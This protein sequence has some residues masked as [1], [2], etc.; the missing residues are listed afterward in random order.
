[1]RI[2][3]LS[4]LHFGL[5]AN[6]KRTQT[7]KNL[8]D[9]Y[10]NG[11]FKKLE[12]IPSVDYILISGDIAFSGTKEEY[13]EAEGWIIKLADI[14]K[15]TTDRIFLCPGNHDVDREELEDKEVP[16]LQT[17]ANELLCI[18]MFDKLS[19]RFNEYIA[20]CA[21]LGVAS[22][23]L[24]G[25]SNYL[26]GIHSAPE[27]NVICVNTSWFAKND[28]YEKSMWV[29]SNF[30]E[31]MIQ[32]DFRNDS[33]TVAIMHHPTSC[34]NE[35]EYRNYEKNENVF[36]KICQMSDI[37]LY[38]HTHEIE[39]DHYY[40]NETY[41]CG[42]GA[43]YKDTQYFHNFHIYE[44]NS[45]NE[46]NKHKMEKIAYIYNGRKWT[47]S[48]IFVDVF[49]KRKAR[50]EKQSIVSVEQNE[51]REEQLDLILQEL[52][53][54]VS[55]QYID[56]LVMEIRND[57]ERIKRLE[58]LLTAIIEN[59]ENP[60]DKI[61]WDN[62]VDSLK[63]VNSKRKIGLSLEGYEG[64]GKS[65][66]LSL[67]YL[68]LRQLNK[69]KKTDR[70]PVLID[71]HLFDTMTLEEA[72]TKLDENLSYIDRVILE[73]N[74]S[75]YLIF[76]GCDNYPR[77]NNELEGK[78]VE[79][80]KK[81][82]GKFILCLGNANEIDRGRTE[83]FHSP[84]HSVAAESSI[85]LKMNLI[86]VKNENLKT[87]LIELRFVLSS[88]KNIEKVSGITSLLRA[89]ALEC[90][91]FRTL[92]MFTKISER[93]GTNL[94][95]SMAIILYEYLLDMTGSVDT[96]F[97]IARISTI[98]TISNED[99]DDVSLNQY[100]HIIYRNK[101]IRDFLFAYYF[102]ETINK[103]KA[104]KENDIERLG[105]IAFIFTAGINRLAKELFVELSNA[106]QL[107]SVNKLIELY[108]S[109]K[110]T[111][112]MKSQ[113][114]YF[115]GRFT[116]QNVKRVIN[117]F[118]ITEIEKIEEE[119]YYKKRISDENNLE[120]KLVLYRTISVSLIAIG[121]AKYE[122]GYIQHLL[123]DEKLKSLN[124]GFH[125]EYYSDRAYRLGDNPNFYDDLE[126]PV[127]KTFPY[128]IG[129][130]N[131]KLD[132]EK[133]SY[134]L[135]LDIITLYSIFESRLQNRQIYHKY[136]DELVILAN[137]ILYSTIVMSPTVKSYISTILELIQANEP[138]YRYI[139]NELYRIKKEKRAGWV[140]RKISDP[141]S[142][143]DH[144]Y[145]SYILGTFLLPDTIDE[146]K[147]YTGITDFDK[148]KNEYNKDTI[149][150]TLLI[151]DLGE[152]Y[153]GDKIDKSETDIAREN[154][155]FTYY[156]LLCTLKNIYGMKQN[157][158]LWDD[159]FQLK[160]INAQ[161]A[162]DVD[163]LEAL[164]QAYMY[165]QDKN[166]VKLKEWIESVVSSLKTS[167]GEALLKL[168]LDNI[169][170]SDE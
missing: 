9:N 35:G 97:E 73:K 129:C 151:H 22:F 157:K 53:K 5:K 84:L 23:S 108:K 82:K 64:T 7:E 80:I 38:G 117:S 169:I 86:P 77:K 125:V 58:N 159:F 10:F 75:I 71:L 57:K 61:D 139:F 62:I 116:S 29:G 112:P 79:Y 163:K 49:N 25:R 134:T 46:S 90:V 149:L 54:N 165:Y 14:C 144:I 164:V 81:H 12:N 167:L 126:T 32:E 107:N 102:V 143:A 4:D 85:R 104:S 105:K 68:R 30:I 152:A 98:Y 95:K 131:S 70:Y 146:L 19:L 158:P 127:D 138:T 74:I 33:I 89:G 17:R 170:A 28:T 60:K 52:E 156:A 103:N 21:R 83:S 93:A 122:E 55:Y 141:E 76:D 109:E 8:R 72:Q 43:V 16:V 137:K 153:I 36:A 34:W 87:L 63:Q 66:F 51:N 65:T 47:E 56:S 136:K 154:E 132:N 26:V 3:H 121:E 67:L 24:N 96:L 113:I 101:L 150:K 42:G 162:Y 59:V 142:I 166:N 94:K 124:C 128:L 20:F 1:M 145:G 15:V 45:G 11:F 100:M 88:N 40:Q 50:G 37:I 6:R 99:I 18:E 140:K 161:I 44:I 114:C 111:M 155:R 135:Y 39:N 106:G 78:I 92:I 120:M 41:I 168:I 118:L 2:L 31:M 130:I 147:D 48:S 27:L 115:M 133:F 13:D 91:D 119:L 160:K 123:Y 69:L 148:Y 110:T